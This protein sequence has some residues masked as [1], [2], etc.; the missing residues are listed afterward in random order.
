MPEMSTYNP[1][2]PNMHTVIYNFH[3]F[4]AINFGQESN[5]RANFGMTKGLFVYIIIKSMPIACVRKYNV[6]FR[7]MFVNSCKLFTFYV[8]YN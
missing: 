2:L 6:D 4:I 1:L 5:S 8:R 7:A 3:M